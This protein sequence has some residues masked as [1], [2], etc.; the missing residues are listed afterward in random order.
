MYDFI[1]P[2]VSMLFI[3]NT[4]LISIVLISWSFKNIKGE[5]ITYSILL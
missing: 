2:I 5:V 4:V 3:K 1:F